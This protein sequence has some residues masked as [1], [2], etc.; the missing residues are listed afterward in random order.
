MGLMSPMY[1][2][3]NLNVQVDGYPKTETLVGRAVSLT[4]ASGHTLEQHWQTAERIKWKAT[5]GP[6]EGYEQTENY[7]AFEIAPG[8]ILI[9]WIEESTAATANGP[10]RP[11]P[12]L[13][14]VIL[15]F[16]TQRAMASWTGPTADG[17][18]E[19]VL[20]QASMVE[21]TCDLN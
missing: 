20:D 12:W 2:T 8:L 16:N 13:T 17:G 15:D 9:S 21:I 6:L 1:C 19:H 10:Q 11:G 7:I 5:S 18:S 14:D 3:R 4:Y